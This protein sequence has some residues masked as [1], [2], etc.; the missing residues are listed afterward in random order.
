M[1]EFL[2]TVPLSIKLLGMSSAKSIFLSLIKVAN[3]RG[4]LMADAKPLTEISEKP[5]PGT[6][7]LLPDLKVKFDRMCLTVV[8]HPRGYVKPLFPPRFHLRRLPMRKYRP[9][10]C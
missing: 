5:L 1:I 7:R 3:G 2:L 9:F 4:P 10:G 8:I 6:D